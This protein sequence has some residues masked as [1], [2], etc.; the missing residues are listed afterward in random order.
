MSAVDSAGSG[1]PPDAAAAAVAAADAASHS[2]GLVLAVLASAGNNIGKALQKRGTADLPRMSLERK[3]LAAYAR[4]STWRLGFVLDVSGAVLMLFALQQAPLSV[5][6]AHAGCGLRMA[7]SACLSSRLPV[8][9]RLVLARRRGRPC[10]H[11]QVQPIAG[12]GMAVLAVF[13]HAYLREEL[14]RIEW[15]GVAVAAMGTIGVGTFVTPTRDDDELRLR[16]AGLALLAAMVLTLAGLELLV[17]AIHARGSIVELSPRA[18]ALHELGTGVQVRAVPGRARLAVR[19]TGAAGW[20]GGPS[21]APRG[22][23]ALHARRVVYSSGSPQR[24]RVQRSC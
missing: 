14:R 5:V 22:R 8:R 7:P 4:H 24:P 19:R 9:A 12:S 10:P 13:S 18:R 2:L 15:L 23:P 20:P 21:D 11:A 6:R 16:W 1:V 17:R 3:V